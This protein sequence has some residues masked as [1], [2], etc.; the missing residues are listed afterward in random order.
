MFAQLGVI[1]R[2][3][4]EFVEIVAAAEHCL[5]IT[6]AKNNTH[7][8]DETASIK[9]EEISSYLVTILSVWARWLEK[10]NLFMKIN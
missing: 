5:I 1:P 4:N 7:L 10:Q 8:A 2:A 3:R 9:K 6:H